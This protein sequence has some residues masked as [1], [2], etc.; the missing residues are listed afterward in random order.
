MKGRKANRTKI[1]TS[2][3]VTKLDIRYGPAT[4]RNDEDD[5]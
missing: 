5:D 4:V 1:D 3:N 2:N